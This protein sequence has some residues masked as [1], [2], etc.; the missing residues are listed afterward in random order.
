MFRAEDGK[1][2][3]VVLDRQKVLFLIDSGG[4]SREIKPTRGSGAVRIENPMEADFTLIVKDNYS[5]AL[6]DGV[7][8]GEYALSQS[9]P[10]QGRLGLT[11]LSGTNRDY[12]TRCEITDLYAWSPN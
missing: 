5:Y 6:V 1:H 9:Q 8:V 11:V 7:L 10:Y 3:A 4:G 2:Y 12:G